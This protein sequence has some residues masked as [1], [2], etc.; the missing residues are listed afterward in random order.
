MY[1]ISLIFLWALVLVVFGSAVYHAICIYSAAAFFRPQN[2]T[3]NNSFTPPV[4]ILKPVRGVD[5]RAYE[6][7]VSCCKQDYPNYEIVFGLRDE[8]DPA[9]PLIKQ[10]QKDYPE[11]QIKLV[12]SSN[13]IGVSAKVSNLHNTLPSA[14]HEILVISDSDIY[15]PTNYL[16]SV[17][18]PFANEKIGVVT[19][20]YRAVGGTNFAALL[21]TIGITGEFMLGVLVARQ[22][23]G[24]KFALGSTVATRK[25]VLSEI[26]GFAAIADYLSDDFL[27]GNLA[28][29]IGY[30]VYIS[31]CIVE[32]VV[33]DYKFSDF[34]KHQLRW[35]RGTRASRPAGYVGMLFT[36]TTA[37][38]LLLI[39]CF[40]F[41]LLAWIV[42]LFA[43]A[44][45]FIA[46]W[47]I[48]GIW[49]GD[50]RLKRYFYLLPVRDLIS[51]GIWLASFVGNTVY[52][53]GDQF[54]LEVGG[55]LVRVD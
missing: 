43:L 37:L 41:T 5:D 55:K 7:W 50:Q 1:W 27:I 52:W 17:V 13:T 23:E 9:I 6:C 18:A 42:A 11:R 34:I 48:G 39:A 12:I 47:L 30:E 45:R 10:L 16:R 22:L 28:A 8:D 26:G 29:N 49:I 40:P 19:C 3:L 15:V 4:T 53:R 21:E 31:E 46:G 36:F 33:P 20:L 2:K 35:A 32:T 24:V 25:K 51:F 54:R 44:V 14:S 38:A